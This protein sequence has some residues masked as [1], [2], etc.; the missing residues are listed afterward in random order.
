MAILATSAAAALP[1]NLAPLPRLLAD[2]QTLGLE[3]SLTRSKRG[4]TTLA[5]VV[6]WLVLAWRG[7]GRPQPLRPLE[8]PLLAAVRGRERLPCPKT[9]H[10]S[11]TSFSAQ[12]VRAAVERAYRAELAQRAGRIWVALDAHQVPDWGRG[13]LE[14]FQQGW[15]GS[16]SRRLRGDRLSLAVETDTGPVSTDRLARGTRRD[17]SLIAVFA[18]HLRRLLGRRLAGS[19]ADG[20]FTSRAAVAAL[21]GSGVPFLLGCARSAPLKRRLAALSPQPRAALRAGGALR[22]GG[23]AWDDRLR[24]FARGARSPTDRRG[25]WVSGTNSP[26]GCTGIRPTSDRSRSADRGPFGLSTSRAWAVIPA[27]AA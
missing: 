11:L 9:L 5:L 15:P 14:R 3:R 6:V 1:T 2:A 21:M 10:R 13:Q 26:S 12:G 24:L 4:I 20:G 8:E 23:W 27:M 19:V 7:S 25:P 16:H 22:L 17:A 18:R